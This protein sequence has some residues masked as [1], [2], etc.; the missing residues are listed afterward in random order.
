MNLART[1]KA[2][3]KNAF[4]FLIGAVL[5]SAVVV[6]LVLPCALKEAMVDKEP[7][8]IIVGALV[9]APILLIIYGI[10]GIFIGGFGVVIIYNLARFI[11]G[12][13]RGKWG[14]KETP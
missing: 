3:L 12:K 9:L 1:M 5:G 14:R 6:Q 13:R 4:F 8:G 10:L 7:G 11:L 2:I